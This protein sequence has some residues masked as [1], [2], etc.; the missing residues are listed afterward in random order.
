MPTIN[1]TATLQAYSRVPFYGDYIRQ[2]SGELGDAFDPNTI[3][4]LKD[5]KWIDLAEAASDIGASVDE[6]RNYIQQV[7]NE[8][9]EDIR[10]VSC[11]IDYAKQS[12]KFVDSNG[13]EY[14]YLLPS[15]R[16][17]GVTIGLNSDY[18]LFEIF[19]LTLYLFPSCSP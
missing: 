17:D 15:A 13:Q 3:Y 14:F 6:L 18:L 12:L 5:S 2:P 16:T 11:S 8:L 9:G 10:T 4:V 7:E 1:L 19:F